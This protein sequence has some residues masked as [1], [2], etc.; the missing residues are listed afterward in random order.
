LD[1]GQFQKL[2]F[3]L[4]FLKMQQGDAAFQ[5]VT[6]LL[7]AIWKPT[8]LFPFK[9]V[10]GM[11][12]IVPDDYY[13]DFVRQSAEQK[14]IGKSLQIGAAKSG[15]SQMK[16]LR[17]FRCRLDAGNQFFPKLVPKPD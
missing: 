12:P 9:S 15:I 11:T 2:G 8:R 1:L 14:V 4:S 5:S 10:V 17:V 3:D 16:M 7:R 6:F 13:S